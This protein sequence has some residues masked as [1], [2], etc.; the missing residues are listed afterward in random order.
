[1]K[2]TEK[3]WKSLTTSE[4]NHIHYYFYELQKIFKK[5]YRM[6]HKIPEGKKI[7]KEGEKE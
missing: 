7:E 3:W 5:I 1:M 4:Q 2:D 6:D